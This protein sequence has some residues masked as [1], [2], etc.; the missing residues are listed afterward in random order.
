MSDKFH[1]QVSELAADSAMASSNKTLSVQLVQAIL[2]RKGN[3][4]I[5]IN[6]YK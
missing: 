2:E 3:V 5:P 6:K 4:E 1:A